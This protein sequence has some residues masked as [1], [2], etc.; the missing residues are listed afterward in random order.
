MRIYNFIAVL[1]LLLLPF[2]AEAQQVSALKSHDTR[3]PLDISADHLELQQKQGRAIFSG[4]VKIT[5]A[6]LTMTSEAVTVFYD[7]EKGSDKPTMQRL[8]AR[9]GV[10]ITSDSEEVTGEWGIYDIEERLI[11]L[12]GSVRMVRGDSLITG[13]R[14]ELDLTSGIIKMD[15]RND[16]KK[17][18]KGQ[19]SVPEQEE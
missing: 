15:G 13:S 6:A 16:P 2:P 3:S 12:G 19:F 14:L 18:V 4:K 11:T 10:V 1:A 8:D 9:G 17:R 7:L 5:Q